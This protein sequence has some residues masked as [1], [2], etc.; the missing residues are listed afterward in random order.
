MTIIKR[1]LYALYLQN[2]QNIAYKVKY[3]IQARA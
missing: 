2:M 3:E 1:G